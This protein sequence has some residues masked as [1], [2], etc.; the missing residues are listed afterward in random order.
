MNLDDQLARHLAKSPA[1]HPTAFIA[2]S[3]DVIGDVTLG[4]ESSVWF[5]TVL[6]ADIHRIVIGPR[7]N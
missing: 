1:I 3:A 7:S 6:R 2:P 5:Q 4:A